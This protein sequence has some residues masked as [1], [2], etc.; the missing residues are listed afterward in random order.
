MDNKDLAKVKFYR[1]RS[2]IELSPYSRIE[3][4]LAK[5]TN[6][7]GNVLYDWEHKLQTVLG[8]DELLK[9]IDLINKM[10]KIGKVTL[11]DIEMNKKLEKLTLIFPHINT[12]IPKTITIKPQCY[13]KQLQLSISISLSGKDEKQKPEGYKNIIHS[14]DW[15]QALGF[16][17]FCEE[18]FKGEMM[19]F[20]N[21]FKDNNKIKSNFYSENKVKKTMYLDNIL[22]TDVEIFGMKILKIS[23]D[24]KENEVNYL[25]NG[26][27]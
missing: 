3:M 22:N 13:Q 12:R 5:G 17:M 26:K 23:Y 1:K 20:I 19:K 4:A 7:S 27:F 25:L 8:T 6:E 11:E 24:E 15:H 16:K 18:S 21:N 10:E 2:C 9:I 14:L